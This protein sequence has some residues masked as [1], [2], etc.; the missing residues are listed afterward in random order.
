M[1]FCKS[2]FVALA[3]T[4]LVACGVNPATGERQFA[5]LMPPAQ[6]AKVGAGEHEKIEQQFG[7]GDLGRNREQHFERVEI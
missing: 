7:K 1:K 6:E 2:L 3:F 5:G 4:S